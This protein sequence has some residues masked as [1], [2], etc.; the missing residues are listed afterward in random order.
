MDDYK[1]YYS[2]SYSYVAAGSGPLVIADHK[3]GYLYSHSY[4]VAGISPLI[5]S[6]PKATIQALIVPMHIHFFNRRT[7]HEFS[8][9]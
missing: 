4:A 6:K 9:C 3:D 8:N 2:S 1:D 7:G 5:M